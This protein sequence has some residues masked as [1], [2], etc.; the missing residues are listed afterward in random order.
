MENQNKMYFFQKDF[1]W[2]LTMLQT[3]HFDFVQQSWINLISS[4]KVL[5]RIGIGT[6]KVPMPMPMP[7]PKK[8]ADSADADA[9]A[10]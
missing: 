5:R 6:S 3:W 10:D 4:K 2:L 7:I 8:H 9:D 1:I